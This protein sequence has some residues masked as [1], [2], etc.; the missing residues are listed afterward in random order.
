MNW[1]FQALGVPSPHFYE[2]KV[3]CHNCRLKAPL[4]RPVEYSV[5]TKCCQF[6][7]TWSAF[8]VGAWLDQNPQ[9]QVTLFHEKGLVLTVLGILHPL[10]HRL[11]RQS[12]CLHFQEGGGCGVWTQR[13]PICYSFFCSSQ[14]KEGLLTYGRLEQWLL[15][16]EAQALKI[17]FDQLGLSSHDWQLWCDFMDLQPKNDTLPP[18][19]QID[20]PDQAEQIYRKSFAALKSEPLQGF[21]L[22]KAEE[23]SLSFARDPIL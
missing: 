14:H 1:I 22:K 13:P 21:F 20:D 4:S 7:P 23:W 6:S 19:L 8:A 2:P 5:K 12:L 3:D 11:D 10:D 9:Q 17:W 15:N 18:S 16:T